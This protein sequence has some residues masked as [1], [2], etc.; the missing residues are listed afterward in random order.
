[1]LEVKPLALLLNPLDEL[2][3]LRPVVRVRTLEHPLLARCGCLV[4][5]K[6]A[7]GF[8]RPVDL[9]ATRL[10]WEVIPSAASVF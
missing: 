1:M 5:F 3:E 4:V 6:N 10:T 2:A 7:K 9:P 8:F